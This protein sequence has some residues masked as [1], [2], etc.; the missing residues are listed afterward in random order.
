MTSAPIPLNPAQR[1][2]VDA[3]GPLVVLA[4]PGTGKTRVITARIARLVGEG[5][6]PHSIVALTFTVKAA[7]EMRDRLARA[8]GSVKIAERVRLGTFH[9]FG[10]HLLARFGDRLGVPR[11][12]RLID[13]AERRRLLRTL[14]AEHALFPEGAADRWQSAIDRSWR[15]I[16][17][18]HHAARTPEEARAY[19]GAW[20]ERLD[21]D[22]SD[23][24][25]VAERAR[26][27]EF[28]DLS[29]LFAAFESR[30]LERGAFVFDHLITW[31]ITLLR[32]NTEVA[33]IVRSE[34][35]HAVVDEF[36]D[37]NAGQIALLDAMFPPRGTP[38][39]CVVGDDDQAIYGFRGADTRAFARF[40]HQ[41]GPIE[42]IALTDN[43]RSRANLV[44]AGQRLIERAGERF[45]PDKALRAAGAAGPGVF[46]ATLVDH[47]SRSGA[48]IAAEIEQARA[49]DPALT[50]ADFAVICRTNTFAD[51]IAAELEVRGVPVDRRRREAPGDDAAV[52]DVLAW[53]E[54]IVDE[55]QPAW[56]SRVLARPP[57][58]LDP[59]SLRESQAIW[60]RSR[61]RVDGV[62]W[63]AWLS[64]QDG[65]VALVARS[66]R[67][68]LVELRVQAASSPASVIVDEVIRRSGVAHAEPRHPRER[69]ARVRSLVALLRYARVVQPVLEPPGG[70]AELLGH[71]AALDPNERAS[72]AAPSLDDL[73]DETDQRNGAGG[74]TVITAHGAKGL[75]FDTVFIPRVR[76]GHGFPLTQRTGDEPVLPDGFGVEPADRDDEERRLMYVAMTRAHRCLHLLARAMKSKK[77]TST[78]YLWELQEHGAALGLVERTEDEVL[79]AA[80]PGDTPP[81]GAE[82]QALAGAG[83][84]RELEV[85]RA[86]ARA[87]AD[88]A[89]HHVATAP[90][91]E[92]DIGIAT[93]E[94]ARAAQL[95]AAVGAIERG[96]TGALDRAELSEADALRLRRVSTR[97]A[98]DAGPHLVRPLE[99]PLDL[100]YTK[101]NAYLTCP[102]SFYVRF[103][104]G[105]DE[106]PGR[107]L[108][109]GTLVHAGME[110]VNELIRD[111]ES[112]GRPGPTPETVARLITDRMHRELRRGEVL[113]EDELQQA[114]T[115]AGTAFEMH[116][117]AQILEVERTVRFAYEHAGHAHVFTAKLDRIDQLPD[118]RLRIVDYKTGRATKRL[119]EPVASDLQLGIYAL[120]LPHLLGTDP[121]EPPAGVAEYWL[122]PTGERGSIDLS[123]LDLGKIRLKINEA[124]EG[125]LAG[126]WDP[127]PQ[128]RDRSGLARDLPAWFFD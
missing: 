95:L 52:Q 115:Q 15:F 9:R 16:A 46:T 112:E 81:I 7:E 48:V 27:H 13:S 86:R 58:A 65:P 124:I 91:D 11:E 45:D 94:L 64:S 70:V 80:S 99:P 87:I 32:T 96:D 66:V 71:L 18:A 108:R 33:A 49:D 51:E 35:R 106:A 69:A 126:R 72:L 57:L 19:A 38:D 110:R 24:D 10:A 31:P 77:S 90:P 17:A 122:A 28:A 61:E 5:A 105:L 114:I 56:V 34:L 78:Q 40:E 123:R 74:V 42:R 82:H 44:D 89:L 76:P 93:R 4:G 54:L 14:I 128:E 39:V 21:P 59:A 97:T 125:M 55:D 119:L 3:R 63:L 12:R 88:A 117:G 75:E 104:L 26:Q 127:A 68:A 62:T 23:D 41:W 2:A 102:R 47:D 118:G 60:L 121:D 43:Y 98:G 22:A 111:A 8:L 120:A 73:E 36:Q 84:V 25:A 1:R 113:D 37:V 30:C 83:L 100:T 67:A 50:H 109:T 92:T 20:A 29:E 101:V 53:L 79:A 103:V 116:D 107:A 85:E 6:E